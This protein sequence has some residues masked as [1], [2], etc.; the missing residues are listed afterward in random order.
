MTYPTPIDIN[1]VKFG[2]G[3]PVALIAGPCVIESEELC[4]RIAER[5]AE[6]G[7][8]RG[9]GVIFKASFDKANRSSVAS[10]RGPGLEAGLRILAKVRE[11]TGL[12]IETDIH[13]AWQA[14]PAAEVVDMLQIPAFLCRQ[15]DL[16]VAAG[17]TGKPVAVKKGQ[18]IS[19]QEMGNAVA[20]VRDTGNPQVML[21]ERGTAFGYQNLVVDMRSLPIMRSFDCPVV[22]D[23]THSVQVP[24]GLGHATGGQREFVPG[25]VRAAAGIGIDGLFLETHPDPSQALSD[26]AT[27]LPLEELEQVVAAAQA[28]DALVKA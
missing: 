10:F 8:R 15:T 14:E 21:V 28:I 2:G 22:F 11:R 12:P 26:G 1:G 3:A 27:M 5:V 18:F 9:I 13:E 6:I 20:K 25:L 23:A 19:P 17:K 16:L 7:Q 24:G 4:L